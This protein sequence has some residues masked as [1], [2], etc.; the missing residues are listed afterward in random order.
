MWT[1][2]NFL[3]ES[4]GWKLIKTVIDGGYGEDDGSWERQNLRVIDRKP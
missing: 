1:T 4:Q 2:G 3:E